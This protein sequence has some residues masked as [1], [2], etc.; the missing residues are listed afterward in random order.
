MKK[1]NHVCAVYFSLDSEFNDEQTEN[2]TNA[3][4]IAAC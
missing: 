1:F 2:I 3:E 4:F